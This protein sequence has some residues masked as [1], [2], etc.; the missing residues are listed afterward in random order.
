MTFRGGDMLDAKTI[1]AEA[2]F[3]DLSFPKMSTSFEELSN[4]IE[5]KGESEFSTATFDE[6]WALYEEVK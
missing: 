6:L 3:T 2:S 4:Y 1:F 5:M